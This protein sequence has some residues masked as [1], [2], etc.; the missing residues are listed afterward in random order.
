MVYFRYDLEKIEMSLNPLDPFDRLD[1]RN[2]PHR[3]DYYHWRYKLYRTQTRMLIGG[4]VLRFLRNFWFWIILAF[5][6]WIIIL[7]CLGMF[8]QNQT[9]SSSTS[10]T[11]MANVSPAASPNAGML[12]D[13][14][15]F[16]AWQ[17]NLLDNLHPYVILVVPICAL[18]YL[19]RKFGFKKEARMIVWGSV[20]A[21]VIVLFGQQLW[22]IAQSFRAPWIT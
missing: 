6:A 16:E 8:M 10:Y 9:A 5:I 21:A 20:V 14:N 19:V 2:D 4:L 11:L 17:N 18:G 12:F 3:Q 22:Q 1:E 15:R 13:K 7:G